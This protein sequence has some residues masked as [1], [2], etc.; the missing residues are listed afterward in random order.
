MKLLLGDICLEAR[1]EQGR[2]W[3]S[4]C[5]RLSKSDIFN[6]S[7]CKLGFKCEISSLTIQGCVIIIIII[8]EMGI[9]IKVCL[10]NTPPYECMYMYNFLLYTPTNQTPTLGIGYRKNACGRTA[11]KHLFFLGG[12]SDLPD[13][14]LDHPELKD[15]RNFK[16]FKKIK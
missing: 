6:C 13:D 15:C 7:K 8:W 16:V 14:R 9:K 4:N 3:N 11:E 5:L 12:R 1:Q 10:F 2:Q